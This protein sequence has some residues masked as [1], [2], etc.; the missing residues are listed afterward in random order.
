MSDSAGSN[1]AGAPRR[2][3]RKRVVGESLAAS[4]GVTQ[5]TGKTT[6]RPSESSRQDILNSAAY[7][8][9]RHPFRE[10]TVPNLM[11]T[12]GLVRSAF[13]FHFKDIYAVV[14]AL[15]ADFRDRVLED[16]KRWAASDASPNES[17]K[18]LMVDMVNIWSVNGPM[19]SA[20]IDATP[21]HPR[22]ELI[23]AEIH[24]LYQRG[25]AEILRREHEAGRVDAMDFEEMATILV[26]GTQGYLQAKLGRPA[27]RDPLKAVA[28]LQALW[29]R[30][31]YRVNP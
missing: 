10:L 26:L 18:A 11:K 12:T 24:Q 29:L 13:Y 23:A 30:A 16:V 5:A 19:I 31:I 27:R 9:N 25:V 3:R 17:L 4:G 22:L 7:F 20:L 8:L 21:E 2:Y 14:E 1:G 15:L 6:R 28:T